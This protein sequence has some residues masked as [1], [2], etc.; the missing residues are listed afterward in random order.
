MIL[1]LASLGSINPKII[2]GYETGACGS[3]GE[4]EPGAR[5]YEGQALRAALA[6]SVRWF[7]LTVA[8]SRLLGWTDLL[9]RPYYS[10]RRIG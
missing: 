1:D 8:M 6:K 7:V 10:L 4:A 5:G 3:P 2:T 9:R